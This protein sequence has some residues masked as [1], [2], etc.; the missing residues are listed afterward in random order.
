MWND[1]FWKVFFRQP[2]KPLKNGCTKSLAPSKAKPKQIVRGKKLYFFLQFFLHLTFFFKK[3]SR[4]KHNFWSTKIVGQDFNFGN[5]KYMPNLFLA[6][7]TKFDYLKNFRLINTFCKNNN[8]QTK[9]LGQNYYVGQHN[10]E[11]VF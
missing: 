2:K 11:W 4:P 8:W 6:F 1:S 10:F 5:K 9:M 7:L 3:K